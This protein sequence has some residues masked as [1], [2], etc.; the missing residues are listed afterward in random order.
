MN[1]PSELFGCNC[2][3][4]KNGMNLEQF[5][6]ECIQSVPWQW[7][8]L[9]TKNSSTIVGARS[10]HCISVIND[11]IYLLG[12]EHQARVPINSKFYI[13]NLLGIESKIWK[14]IKTKDSEDPPI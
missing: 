14:E 4:C 12:G 1:F 2:Q 13:R 7:I 5:M 3:E 9:E 11:D 6:F 10:S 8:F